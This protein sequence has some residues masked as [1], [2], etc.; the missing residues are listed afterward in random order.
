MI[1]IKIISNKSFDTSSHLLKLRFEISS[2]SLDNTRYIWVSACILHAQNIT[3]F[4]PHIFDT[5]E[6]VFFV[7]A[8]TESVKFRLEITQTLLLLLSNFS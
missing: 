2:S 4:G 3:I 8:A 5:I 7:I 1:I 6:Y